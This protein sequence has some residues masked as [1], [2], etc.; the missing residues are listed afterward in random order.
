MPSA[1]RVKR[2]RSLARESRWVTARHMGDCPLVEQTGERERQRALAGTAVAGDR[3]GQGPPAEAMEI[4]G[5]DAAP[6]HADRQYDAEGADQG[7]PER[8]G[9]VRDMD[10]DLRPSA[11]CS[12]GRGPAPVPLAKRADGRRSA[13]PRRPWS[14]I[15][16]WRRPG[17]G[18]RPGTAGP[19][20]TSR[21]RQGSS[22]RRRR[23]PRPARPEAARSAASES[24]R[25]NRVAAG[26]S[27][28]S[29]R[30][31]DP[32]N[33]NFGPKAYPPGSGD[34]MSC[35]PSPG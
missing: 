18:A 19:R 12:R 34:G 29:G 32:S 8:A 28:A 11:K 26:R 17:P 2:C 21:P 16:R 6:V 9:V 20:D 24:A 30:A 23:R 5:G 14:R 1:S 4:V 33:S 3:Q 7:V 22:A 10:R 15:W 31:T 25:R 35:F 27:M 13:V